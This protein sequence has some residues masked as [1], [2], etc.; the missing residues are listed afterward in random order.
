MSETETKLPTEDPTGL[1]SGTPSFLNMV[2]INFTPSFSTYRN[3]GVEEQMC[4][5]LPHI[6]EADCS[7]DME[8]QMWEFKSS[9]RVHSSYTR[10]GTLNFYFNRRNG[11]HFSQKV[12]VPHGVIALSLGCL[13]VIHCAAVIVSLRSTRVN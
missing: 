12:A 10:P 1:K 13:Y 11:H 8:S 7:W 5:R 2:S 3:Q 9:C 4:I 6:M